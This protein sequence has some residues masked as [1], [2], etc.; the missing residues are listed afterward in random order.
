MKYK[1]I[2]LTSFRSIDLNS[3]YG[4]HHLKEG[5]YQD[6][7]YTYSFGSNYGI[8]EEFFLVDHRQLL[9]NFVHEFEEVE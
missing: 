8:T 7:A 1:W 5:I 9:T 3:E 6:V 2:I 4:A